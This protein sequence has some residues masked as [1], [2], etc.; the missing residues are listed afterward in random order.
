MTA[1]AN[2]FSDWW[3]NQ[4]QGDAMAAAK[5]VSPLITGAE[6]LAAN[7]KWESD[8]TYGEVWYPNNL[9]ED[10]TPYRYG[11]WRYL[12]PW[13][14]TWIDDAAWGF[15]P[16]HY[17]RWARINARWGWVPGPRG[18][19]LTARPRSRFSAPPGSA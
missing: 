5:H 18:V 10:W 12:P 15:A 8:D 17:G 14:W 19:P 3:R 1:T 16:T 7:G 13:G 4:D 6:V 11:S 9:A 2:S